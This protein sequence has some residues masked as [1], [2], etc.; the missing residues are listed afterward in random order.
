MRIAAS[1]IRKPQQFGGG[2][3]GG[4]VVGKRYHNKL[5]KVLFLFSLR[6]Q[7]NFFAALFAKRQISNFNCVEAVAGIICGEGGPTSNCN[8]NSYLRACK[9]RGLFSQINRAQFRWLFAP[10]EFAGKDRKIK[11]KPCTVVCID[12]LEELGEIA[13][14]VAKG[15]IKAPQEPS[16]RLQ[17]LLG[18]RDRTKTLQHLL[19]ILSI[20]L[21]KTLHQPPLEMNLRAAAVPLA[22]M[23]LQMAV[24]PVV[25]PTYFF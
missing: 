8:H 18:I 17:S 20:P 4:W 2:E 24:E 23:V 15:A 6:S 11:H 10:T 14:H 13:L 12:A 16:Q 22:L 19:I 25:S 3:R 7:L 5:S 21:K 1:E 9:L